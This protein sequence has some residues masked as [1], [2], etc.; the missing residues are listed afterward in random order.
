MNYVLGIGWWST[1][2]GVFR[3]TLYIFVYEWV[4]GQEMQTAFYCHSHFSSSA[5]AAAN[6]LLCSLLLDTLRF[7]SSSA[8]SDRR[9]GRPH[10]QE[11]GHQVWLLEFCRP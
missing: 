1:T 6:P 10:S 2:R 11:K 5:A 7:I 4:C 9:G 8:G 3:E